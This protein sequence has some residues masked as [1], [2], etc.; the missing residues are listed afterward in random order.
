M[1]HSIVGI[2]LPSLA[3]MLAEITD[4]RKPKG[5]RYP[6]PPLL[7]L[8][9]VAK[10]CQ[11][12]TPAAIADWV[13]H[14]SALLQAK[15]HLQWKRM[16]SASTWQRLIG[17][18]I[19]A[20]ELDEKVGAYFQM[21]SAADRQLYNLDGKVVRGTVAGASPCQL[22]LLALQEAATNA[23]VEQTE[24]LP[25]EN[26]ISAAKRL[27]A[28]ADLTNKV[29][30]GDAIFAQQDLA[31]TVVEKGGDYLWKLR[32]NQGGLYQAAV[33]HFAQGADKYLDQAQSLEK[34]HGR[35]DERRIVTSFRLAGRL[36]FPYL[37]QVF[38]LERRSEECKSGKVSEQTLYGVTSWSVAEAGAQELLAA[39]R[40][41]W[42]IENGLHRRRDVTFHEDAI[43]NTTK[44]GGR[45][46]AAF[47]NLTIGVLRK[48]GWENLAQARRYF[49]AHI[50]E[51]LKLI[52]TPLPL[53]L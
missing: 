11:Q 41:H 30:S 51:A 16:P 26:E 20:L 1:E 13:K 33:T 27:L 43:R 8:L 15:L 24:L 37:E 49:E 39:T 22:H 4:Q 25:G 23:V 32:A 7:I 52:L 6:L 50:E 2:S 28:Q 40:G 44:N 36:E 35:I 38:R 17:Q 10:F 48:L 12:D 42:G 31:R 14:R 5:I 47:N 45:V 53:L 3:E 19:P 18:K 9:S 29:V 34:G 21:L 46:Q